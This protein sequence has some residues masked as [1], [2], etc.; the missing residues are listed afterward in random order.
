MVTSLI[1]AGHPPHDGQLLT[2]QE[3]SGDRCNLPHAFGIFTGVGARR[4][5]DERFR[6]FVA[7]RSGRLLRTAYLMT[8]DRGHAEDLLQTALL[9]TYRH[10]D[11]L[12]NQ[13]DPEASVRRVMAT[14]LAMAWRRRR[15]A[16]RSVAQLPETSAARGSDPEDRDELW[17]ALATLPPRMRAVLVLRYWE[18]LSET[19][20]SALLGCAVGTVKSQASRGLAR[21]RAQLAR[22]AVNAEAGAKGRS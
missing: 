2:H 18:D 19:E 6:Q 12:R 4:D 21:L 14:S 9:R 11:Q 16:E 10:W 13:D 5:D 15:V 1:A 17:R 8:G 20:T 22:A 7:R 3:E